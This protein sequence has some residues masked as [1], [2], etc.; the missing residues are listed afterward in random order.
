[1]AADLAADPACAEGARVATASSAAQSDPKH[2]SAPPA[3]AERAADAHSA[4]PAEP[5]LPPQAAAEQP[6]GGP[7]LSEPELADPAEPA[8]RRMV[9]VLSD[10]RAAKRAPLAAASPPLAL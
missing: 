10:V 4:L 9:H 2:A 1:M 8:R 5:A 6:D 7:E 3:V